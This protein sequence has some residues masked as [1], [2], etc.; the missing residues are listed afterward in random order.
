MAPRAQLCPTIYPTW[1]NIIH[2]VH[3]A[4]ERLIPEAQCLRSDHRKDH[5]NVGTKNVDESDETQTLYV[6]LD[7]AYSYC[8]FFIDRQLSQT[9]ATIESTSSIQDMIYMFLQGYVCL[10]T[11]I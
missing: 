7:P 11:Y 8:M 1:R 10:N 4:T 3:T 9:K 6:C 5:P 2:A